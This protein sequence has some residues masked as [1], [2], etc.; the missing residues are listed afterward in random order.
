MVK[1]CLRGAPEGAAQIVILFGLL[2]GA[3]TIMV[4]GQQIKGTVR[5]NDRCGSTDRPALHTLCIRML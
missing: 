4:M 5:P 2:G 1:L 3:I